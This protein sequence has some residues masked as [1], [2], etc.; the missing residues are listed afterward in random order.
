MAESTCWALAGANGDR[1]RKGARQR[2]REKYELRTARLIPYQFYKPSN[3]MPPFALG[4][5]LF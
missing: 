2:E 5:L 1:M 4:H 3:F